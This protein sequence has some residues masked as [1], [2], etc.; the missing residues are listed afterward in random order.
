MIIDINYFR[1]S[2]SRIFVFNCSNYYNNFS[3]QFLEIFKSTEN[4]LLDSSLL[5]SLFIFLLF[6]SKL[7]LA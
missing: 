3:I 5:F 2:V 1:V 4:K 7:S 6:F